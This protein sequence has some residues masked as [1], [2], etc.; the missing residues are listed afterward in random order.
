MLKFIFGSSL[1][2]K[3]FYLARK[4]VSYLNKQYMDAHKLARGYK[5]SE[6]EEKAISSLKIIKD[7]ALSYHEIRHGNKVIWMYWN[8]SLDEAPEVVKLSYESWKRFNTSYEVVLLND[9]LLESKLGFDFNAVFEL[10][11]IRLSLANKADLLRLYLLSKYGGVWADATS[12]CIQPLDNWLPSIARENSFFAFRQ[13]K[14]KSRPIEVWFLYSDKGSPII[15]KTLNLFVDY[16]LHERETSIYVS[17]SKKEMLKLGIKKNYPYM[18]YAET[19]YEAENYGFMPY[20]SLAY[21]FN[22]SMKEL[23]NYM[24]IKKFFDL[25]NLFANNNDGVEVFINSYVSKQTYKE[26]YQNSKVYMERKK[27]LFP[28]TVVDL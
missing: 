23:T 3:K 16:L 2:E 20:F 19:V 4:K 6:L 1:F 5:N 18:I 12:F 13:N 26:D 9:Q 21:F 22:Q 7:T 28:S 14:V 15:N 11:N 17:N 10:C 25:P 24:E 8:S 27:L